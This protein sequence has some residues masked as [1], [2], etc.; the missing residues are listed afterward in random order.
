MALT[1]GRV[2]AINR[3]HVVV[4]SFASSTFTV[5]D[6]QNGNEVLA[7]G[8]LSPNLTLDATAP[9]TFSPLGTVAAPVVVTLHRGADTRTVRVGLTGMVEIA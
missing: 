7:T 1:Q 8:S 9:A 6:T 5:I 2:S 4:A 3:G